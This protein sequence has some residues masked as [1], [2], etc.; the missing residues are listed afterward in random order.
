MSDRVTVERK[1]FE[2]FLAE[3][4]KLIDRSQAL[5]NTIDRLEKENRQ[6]REELEASRART[7]LFESSARQSGDS[8]KK[9]RSD[10]SRL[11][12]EA[13]KRLAQ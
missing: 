11:I 1:E 10:L 3:N 2:S 7:Q 13:D 9:A 12:Q 6:L 8:L 4:Q 5:M